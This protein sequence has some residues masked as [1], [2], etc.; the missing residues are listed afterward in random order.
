MLDTSLTYWTPPPIWGMP[1]HVL[2]P[3]LIGWL[4]CASVCLVDIYM[5]YREYSPYVSVLEVFPHMLG[6]GGNLHICQAL[7]LGSA[8]TGCPLGF[9]LYF[10]CSSLCLVSTTATT[11]TR[12]VM[13]VSSWS[14]IYFISDHGPF[15]DG[16]SCNI[17]SV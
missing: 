13:V 8:S 9:I 14:V 5:L 12:P 3:P 2:H 15:L 11:T 6:F 10:F 17:G 4:P 7:V 16:T 1:P